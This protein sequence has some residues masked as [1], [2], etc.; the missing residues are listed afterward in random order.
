MSK[1]QDYW[2]KR[3]EKMFLNGEKDI[4]SFANDLKDNYNIALKQIETELNIFYGKYQTKLG[5]DTTA[6]RKLLDNSELKDF[7]SYLD[8]IIE[9]SKKKGMTKQY[10]EE[11]DLLKTKLRISRL[12]E[13]KTKIEFEIQ[14]LT[15]DVDIQLGDKLKE[16]FENGYYQTIFNNDQLLKFSVDFAA[17]NLNAIE[18]AIKTEYMMEDYS[19]VIWRNTNTLKSLLNKSIPQG[20]ILGYNPKK[21]ANIASKNLK[22][23]Y[24]ATVR[25]IRTEYNLILN[26]AV[27]RGY[28]ECGID[29]YQLL[30]TLDNRTSDI[31]QVM[32]GKIFEVSK[33]EVGVNYP[34]F[35]PNCRTTTIAYFEPDEFTELE[36]R[37]ARDDDG[38]NYYVPGNLTYNQWKDGLK[39]QKD[40][41]LRYGRGDA[42]V[43]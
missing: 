27:A 13:L 39:T 14:K 3:N 23:N 6:L 16:V 34:P 20:I 29:R 15:N 40:G 5:L 9:Y 26:D 22:T 18:K 28:K 1:Y 11:L 4:L 41:T 38:N 30:A 43:N 33:K 37:I 25:L 2:T 19:Q 32:D 8:E 12:E 36:Q 24:N 7:K 10:I 17:L 21:V 42:P 35:H 31:C